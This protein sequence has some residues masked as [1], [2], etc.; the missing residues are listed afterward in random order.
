MKLTIYPKG[1]KPISFS[2]NYTYIICYFSKKINMEGGEKNGI[3]SKK[4]F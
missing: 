3:N 4:R 1:L 2:F